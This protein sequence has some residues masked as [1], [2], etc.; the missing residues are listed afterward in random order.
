MTSNVNL[1]PAPP[2]ARTPPWDGKLPTYAAIRTTVGTGTDGRPA[3]YAPGML[4]A[5]H[6][7]PGRLWDGR[8]WCEVP[9]GAVVA[10][11]GGRRWVESPPDEGTAD[12]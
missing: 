7:A 6:P 8:R 10:V 11:C 12:A 3:F 9:I 5:A 2:T 1:V 4:T